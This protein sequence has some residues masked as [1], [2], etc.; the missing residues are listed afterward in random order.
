MNAEQVYARQMTGAGDIYLSGRSEFCYTFGGTFGYIYAQD[1][2]SN[3]VH[4]DN[5]NSGDIHVHPLS[6]LGVYIGG[7]GNVYYSGSPAIVSEISGTGRLMQ[8]D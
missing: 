4:V 6:S 5:R 2:I 7:S 1:F 8:E 3:S